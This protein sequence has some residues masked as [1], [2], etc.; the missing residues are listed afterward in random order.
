M[1]LSSP[2][3]MYVINPSIQLLFKI[4]NQHLR[5]LRKEKVQC[6]IFSYINS[7]SDHLHSFLYIQI[8]FHYHLSL[9]WGSYFSTSL[10]AMSLSD[11]LFMLLILNCVYFPGLYLVCL[12][13]FIFTFKINSTKVQIT[14][15]RLHLC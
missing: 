6:F 13:V 8:L 15:I 4:V 5:K 1:T 9:L 11:K 10:S 7:I 12:V 2:L 3:V 14:Y